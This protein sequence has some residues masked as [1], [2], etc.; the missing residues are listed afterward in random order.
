MTIC[1]VPAEMAVLGSMLE[2]P[3][4]IDTVTAILDPE[5]YYQPRHEQIHRV[6]VECHDAGMPTDT[7]AIADALRKA[8]VRVEP[9]YLTEL[10]GAVTVAAAVSHWAGIVR[11]KADLRRV[12]A[13]GAR[14]QQLAAEAATEDADRVLDEARRMLDTGGRDADTISTIAADLA[15]MVDGFERGHA[16]GI[17]TPWPDLTR[18]LAGLQ[19]GKVYVV[20]ARPGVGKSL[21]VQAIASHIAGRFGRPVFWA[22]VEMSRH[23]VWSRVIAAHANIPL[24]RLIKSS[25]D[26]DH[27][28]RLQRVT[29]ILN[30]L[31]ITLDDAGM[32]TLTS[33]RRGARELAR[34]HGPLGLVAVDY[35]QIVTPRD[36]RAGRQEQVA[37]MSR[38][39]KVLARELDVPLVLLSQLNRNPEGRADKR[40]TLADLR[41]S[42]A[43]EADA[44]VVLLLHRPDD[45]SQHGLAAIVAKN[46]SGPLTTVDLW[47]RGDV[48]RI[49]S[50]A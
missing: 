49:E 15:D 9:L 27:W 4:A 37:E 26:E 24:D 16:A 3:R 45:E 23:E 11:R 38:G 46:R 18:V 42:G 8:N 32:Q 1:D 41:E 30:A 39:M 12:H 20:A 14:M 13:T 33:I 35:L 48:C 2:S 21:M 29:P 31:P 22:S 25:L 10:T 50:A 19:P 6:I 44:D 43:I 7:I 17:D 40:P 47:L 36:G 28:Q 34:K 5:D